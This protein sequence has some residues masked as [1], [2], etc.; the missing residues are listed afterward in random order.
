MR[1]LLD[2]CVPVRLAR[3]LSGHTVSTVGREGFSGLKNGRLLRAMEGSWDVLLTTD[4]AIPSQQFIG[5]YQMGLLIVRAFSNDWPTLALFIP[6]MRRVLPFIQ[7]GTVTWIGD[8]KL[9]DEAS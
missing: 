1:V 6:E 9:M 2:E 3:H 4:K 7:P 8:P 5:R